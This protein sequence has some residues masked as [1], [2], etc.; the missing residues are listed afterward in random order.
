MRKRIG[1]KRWRCKNINNSI[2]FYTHSLCWQEPGD[3]SFVPSSRLHLPQLHNSFHVSILDRPKEREHV[4]CGSGHFITHPLEI[5]LSQHAN[6]TR[7]F[8]S[9]LPSILWVWYLKS[10][11]SC[12]SS[13]HNIACSTH[14]IPKVQREEKDKLNIFHV[15]STI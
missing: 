8:N 3:L 11:S 7:T 15:Q 13:R 1:P 6:V 10:N 4:S 2:P 14:Y 9:C 12:C 5:N